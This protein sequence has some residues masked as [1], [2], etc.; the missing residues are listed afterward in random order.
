MLDL[1]KIWEKDTN[2]DKVSK[3]PL[4]IPE[5]IGGVNFNVLLSEHNGEAM[6]VSGGLGEQNGFIMQ[7]NFI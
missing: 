5:Y 4:S 3:V 1:K 7:S 2:W 6:E